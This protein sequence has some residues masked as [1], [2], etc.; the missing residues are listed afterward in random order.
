V[1]NDSILLRGSGEQTGVDTVRVIAQQLL[2]RSTL[3]NRSLMQNKNLI[4]MLNSRQTVRN[5][6]CSAAVGSRC[7]S[8]LKGRYIIQTGSK[9]L[10]LKSHNPH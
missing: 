4:S 6:D 2:V 8:I 7:K 10:A 5:D 1:S 3:G 9:A